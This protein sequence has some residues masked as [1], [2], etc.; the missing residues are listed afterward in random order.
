MMHVNPND[1]T[2]MA[3]VSVLFD[4]TLDIDN[5]FVDTVTPTATTMN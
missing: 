3:M 2:E 5:T 1:P 4:S